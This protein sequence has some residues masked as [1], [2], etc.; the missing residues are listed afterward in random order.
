MNDRFI[1]VIM[2]V[3]GFIVMNF[4]EDLDNECIMFLCGLSIIVLSIVDLILR[5][6]LT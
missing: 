3:L 4:F 1:I 6:I 2:G 5:E